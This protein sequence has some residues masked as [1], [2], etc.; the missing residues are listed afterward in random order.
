MHTHIYILDQY[1]ILNGI[2]DVRLLTYAKPVVSILL[3][4]SYLTQPSEVL[5]GTSIL[6]VK[7]IGYSVM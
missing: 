2:K 1:L 6:K 7:P 3:Y 4:V 5:A